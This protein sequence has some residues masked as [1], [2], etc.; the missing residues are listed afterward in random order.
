MNATVAEVM[1][2]K[3]MTIT[4]H[5]TAEH[6]RKLMRDHKV[7]A[8]PVV[9]PDKEPLGIVTASDLLDDHADATPVSSFMSKQVLTVPL[10]EQPHVAA[11]IMRNHHVHHVLVV[12]GHEVAGILSAYDL[13]EL[14]EEHRFVMK[15]APTPSKKQPKRQ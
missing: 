8:L 5:E 4:K 14:V 6:A 15:N 13:L 1:V 11:R 2:S 9:G 3:V 12:D 10:N 7:S